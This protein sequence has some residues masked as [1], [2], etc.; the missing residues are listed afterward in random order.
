MALATERG[1]V[2]AQASEGGGAMASIAASPDQVEPLLPGANGTGGK[3]GA[4]GKGGSGAKDGA[5][6]VIA[7]YNGPAQTVISMT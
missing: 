5:E 1:R 7:G 3:G 2:M 6:V 4:G